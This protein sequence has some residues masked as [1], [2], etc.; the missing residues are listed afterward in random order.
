MATY[1]SLYKLTDQGISDIKNAPKRIEDAIKAWEAAGGKMVGF[2]STMGKYDYIAI[3]EAEDEEQAA[4]FLLA[5]G[6]MGYVRTTT[7]RAYAVDEFAGIVAKIPKL[8]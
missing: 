7:M 2:Y 6:A 3:T 8:G 4:A 1:V 5:I